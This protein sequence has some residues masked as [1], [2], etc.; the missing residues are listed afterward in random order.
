MAEKKGNEMVRLCVVLF[1]I[2][3][4]SATLLGLINSVT[5]P[6]IKLN[7]EKTRGE[8][9]AM[10]IPDSEFELVDVRPGTKEDKMEVMDMN[11]FIRVHTFLKQKQKLVLILHA[12]DPADIFRYEKM[13][14]LL[15]ELQLCT[16][17]YQWTGVL[18]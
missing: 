9:M 16:Q 8:A 6:Q 13:F 10:L 1:L 18:Q 12:R 14:F 3:L 2:T 11:P 5:A 7:K 15:A 17:E 4:I